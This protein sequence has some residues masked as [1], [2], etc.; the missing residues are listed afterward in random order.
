MLGQQNFG[1]TSEYT[2]QVETHFATITDVND[3]QA[4]PRTLWIA[5]YATLLPSPL[6]PLKRVPQFSFTSMSVSLLINDIMTVVF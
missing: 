1:S 2:S 5:K 6:S 3:I 4:S